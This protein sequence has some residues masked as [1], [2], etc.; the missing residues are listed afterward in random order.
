MTRFNPL[1]QFI[2]DSK[3]IKD[4]AAY[5]DWARTIAEYLGQAYSNDAQNHVLEILRNNY[6]D[7]GTSLIKGY[8]IFLLSKGKSTSDMESG[9]QE[10]ESRINTTVESPD[11]EMSSNVFIVHGHDDAAKEAVARFIERLRLNPIIL[12][13]QPDKGKTIIE[14]LERYSE[15]GF[16]IVILSPDDIGASK[17]NKGNPQYRARQN[18]VFELGYFM[19]KLG[20]D[21]VCALYKEKIETPSDYHGVLYVNMDSEGAWKMKIARE[22]K[23]AG[24]PVNFDRAL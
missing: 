17:A 23:A 22:L 21:H 3:N 5:Q 4:S 20:R 8:L 2:E 6:R 15:V 24:L 11:K 16:A 18:V 19:A 1:E 12:H 7:A 9:V 10:S 14:K 13:E